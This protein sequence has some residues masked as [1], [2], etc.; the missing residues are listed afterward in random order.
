MT[1]ERS[2]RRSG[3]PGIEDNAVKVLNMLVMNCKG[4]RRLVFA[5]ASL[6]LLGM[7]LQLVM[8]LFEPGDSA[9]LGFLP[10][11]TFCLLLSAP[12]LLLGSVLLA[13]LPGEN[14]KCTPA[15]AD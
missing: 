11:L 5:S 8:N 6:F 4:M 9:I 15:N 3:S 2:R 7:A 10:Y 13:L 1:F 12:L 14:K